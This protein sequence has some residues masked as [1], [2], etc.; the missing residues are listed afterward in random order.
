MSAANRLAVVACATLAVA[1]P[2]LAGAGVWRYLDPEHRHGLAY[3]LLYWPSIALDALPARAA[4]A[5]TL[6]A[7]P[8]VLIYF[9]GYL[10]LWRLLRLLRLL[11]AL[12]RRG[13]REPA[14]GG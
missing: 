10:L 4:E 14:P 8:T 3:V 5:F 6:S 2:L 9:A 1:T 13:G 11:R 7:L 12:P